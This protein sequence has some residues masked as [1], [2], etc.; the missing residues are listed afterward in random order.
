LD[1]V[2][3]LPLVMESQLRFDAT[4]ARTSM[5]QVHEHE[6]VSYFELLNMHG[7]HGSRFGTPLS[8]IIV[9]M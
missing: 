6:K 1:R 2:L 3:L 9:I 8:F 4:T 7:K 5:L